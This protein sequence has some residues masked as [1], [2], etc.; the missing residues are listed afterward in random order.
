MDTAIV[1][2]MIF[3]CV[4]SV[5]VSIALAHFASMMHNTDNGSNLPLKKIENTTVCMQSTHVPTLDLVNEVIAL[6]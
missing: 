5:H 2:T 3:L 1:R 6:N 4:C